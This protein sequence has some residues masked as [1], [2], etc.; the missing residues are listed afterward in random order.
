[1]LSQEVKAADWPFFRALEK[2]ISK[3]IAALQQFL[4]GVAVAEHL[5][6]RQK[7][8]LQLLCV[9]VILIRGLPIQNFGA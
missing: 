9:W 6:V 5:K 3:Q 2:I 4:V 1:M 8:Q 7:R